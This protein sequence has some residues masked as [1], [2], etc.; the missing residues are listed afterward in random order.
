MSEWIKWN[1]SAS[2]ESPEP[3]G[4]MLEI[5]WLQGDIIPIENLDYI[6]WTHT[7]AG[8]DILAYRVISE[9]DSV[10]NR[11]GQPLAITSYPKAQPNYSI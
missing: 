4:E 8:D 6:R 3:Y 5:Q 9:K 11:M 7:G 10:K 2:G 1:G